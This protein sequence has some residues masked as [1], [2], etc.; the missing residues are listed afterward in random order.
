VAAVNDLVEFLRARLA[1]DEQVA[2]YSGEP[3]QWDIGECVST[4]EPG[5]TEWEIVTENGY[6]TART[7]TN[8]RAAHI[9]RHDPARV[10][11]EVEAKRQIVDAY[12]EA[13]RIQDGFRETTGELM[14]RTAIEMACL[15]YAVAYAYHPD[16]REEWK[17]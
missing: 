11:R 14:R 1:E 4:D 10:L 13:L 6:V 12:A 3:G 2:R 9:A 17:P 7:A 5:R 8:M 16:Y 15:A